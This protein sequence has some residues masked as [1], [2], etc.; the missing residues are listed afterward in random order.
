MLKA[1]AI[2]LMLNLAATTL[3]DNADDHAAVIDVATEFFA[4]MTARDIDK[5]RTMMTPD[6]VL[7]GYRE[8]PD[9]LQLIRP[10]HAA[11]LESLAGREGT[12]VERFW[13]P[14]VMIDGRMAT[15]WTPYDFHV[16]GK[17]S[18][19]GVNNF[20]LLRTDDRWIITGVVFSMQADNCKESPLGPLQTK[21]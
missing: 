8:T 20:S 18:H 17:F 3:A 7:Y 2:F 21:R 12:L 11:Y 9:G 4:A 1:I 16:D 13:D 10:T 14:Q 5:L 19:C 6:G 15:L